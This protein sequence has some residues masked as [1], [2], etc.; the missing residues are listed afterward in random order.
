MAHPL[1][2]Y[3]R[4]VQRNVDGPPPSYTSCLHFVQDFIDLAKTMA[5][6]HGRGMTAKEVL[7]R[8]WNSGKRTKST[9]DAG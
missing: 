4:H 5:F 9:D 6:N 7:V 2:N 1:K 8:M 3:A